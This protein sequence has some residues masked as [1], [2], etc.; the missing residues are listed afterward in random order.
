M[1]PALDPVERLS[2]HT[3]QLWSLH[4]KVAWP[5]ALACTRRRAIA[6]DRQHRVVQNVVL[7]RRAQGS[8]VI[9]DNPCSLRVD[10]GSSGGAS[11]ARLCSSVVSVIGVCL[12]LEVVFDESMLQAL[13]FGAGECLVVLAGDRV[14]FVARMCRSHCGV[15]AL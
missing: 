12:R 6:V 13:E 1:A 7:V 3:Q 9:V 14:V 2:E 15:V 4:G 10:V 11:A 5:H 8:T